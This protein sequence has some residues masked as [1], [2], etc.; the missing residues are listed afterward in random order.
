MGPKTKELIIELEA[1]ANMLKECSEIHWGL[2]LEECASLLKTGNF[3]GIEKFEGAFGGMGSIN[4]LILH[5]INKHN[6][7]E[8]EVQKYNER[9]QKHLDRCLNLTNEIRQNAAYN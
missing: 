3:R 8:S 5:P 2:W 7:S 6:I 9:L 4:D 1:C